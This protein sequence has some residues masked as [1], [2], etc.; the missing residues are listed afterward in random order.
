MGE[1]LTP[2]PLMVIVVIALLFFG[3][4]KLP[5]KGLGESLRGFKDAVIGLTDDNGPGKAAQTIVP[6]PNESLR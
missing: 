1:L 5:G 3:G 2:T 4:N 6:K